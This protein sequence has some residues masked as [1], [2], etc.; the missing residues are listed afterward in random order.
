VRIIGTDMVTDT[1]ATLPNFGKTKRYPSVLPSHED[2][3][4][5][6][7]TKHDERDWRV[8]SAK[9]VSFLANGS[10]A[11]PFARTMPALTQ[12][13]LGSEDSGVHEVG[14]LR[15]TLDP[16]DRAPDAPPPTE[17]LTPTLRLRR[18]SQPPLKRA[19]QRW[20]AQSPIIT[21]GT[22]ATF[23]ILSALLV[24]MLAP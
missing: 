17:P 1:K 22:A 12:E 6:P 11:L 18:S 3:I 23:C 16:S 13:D 21:I 5:Q 24:S 15:L 4:P 20:E 19:W 14:G 7:D 10:E 2:C 8:L 9:D